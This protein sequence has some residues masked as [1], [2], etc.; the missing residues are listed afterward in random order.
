MYKDMQ[1]ILA[2]VARGDLSPDE[3]EFEMAAL[4]NAQEAAKADET[5][6]EAEPQTE[7]IEAPDAGTQPEKAAEP[8]APRSEPSNST[9]TGCGNANRYY[10]KPP[11][12]PKVCSMTYTDFN[13][14]AHDWASSITQSANRFAARITQSVNRAFGV[15]SN[16]DDYDGP[17][18]DVHGDVDEV[19]S[20][21]VIRGCLY[22]SVKGNVA[23]GAHICD[24]VTGS[25]SGC[26]AGLIDGDLSGMIGGDLAASGCIGGDLSGDIGG[27]LAGE[28]RGDCI[29]N[30]GKDFSGKVGGDFSGTIGGAFTGTISGDCKGDIAGD[31]SGKVSGDYRGKVA[32]NFTGSVGGDYS[33]DIAGNLTGSVSGDYR[34]TVTG[35]LSGHVHGD[36]GVICGNVSGEIGGDVRE[37]RGDI[38]PGAIIKGDVRLLCGSNHGTVYGDIRKK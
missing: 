29:S 17:A 37:I 27:N 33:G 5:Q 28:V 7:W 19:R 25:V 23:E 21:E 9:D 24:D 6:A 18:G 3:A 31:L 32:G 15:G 10:V 22:G 36:C 13:G 11:K 38:L 35:D 34:G 14:D 20:G 2:A 1:E 4:D 26:M 16:S 30:I 12:P 8:D